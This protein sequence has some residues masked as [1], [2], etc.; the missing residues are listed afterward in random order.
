MV[1]PT[2]EKDALAAAGLAS[3]TSQAGQNERICDLCAGR[4]ARRLRLYSSVSYRYKSAAV[5]PELSSNPEHFAMTRY[6]LL[7]L[8]MLAG[9]IVVLGGAFQQKPK[10]TQPL[11]LTDGLRP[12]DPQALEL[13]D[14]AAAALAPEQVR[15]MECKVWQQGICE[16]FSYQGCGRL[17]TAPDERC[18][19]DLNVKVG[20]T[21]G[22]LRLVSDGKTLCHS[23]R[24]SGDKAAATR[25]DLPCA[26]DKFKTPLELGQARAQFLNDHGGAS[27]S[28]MLRGLRLR[29]KGVQCLQCRWNSHEVYVIAGALPQEQL[30]EGLTCEFVPA[31]FQCRQSVLYLDSQTMW[32]LRVEW[33]GAERP[34]ETS[35]LLLQTE[36]RSPVLNQ[37]LS[38]ERC[39]A[40]FTL[41]N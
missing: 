25:L 26:K 7:L 40:E 18:R 14:R 1:V 34:T 30:P 39:A 28:A 36:F 24:M 41:P 20:N 35:K 4:H 8:P 37:P 32:P 19:F 13:L 16:E 5:R 12:S 21:V 6:Q 38:T 15:W 2:P 3:R 10:T 33:W 22:E 17:L 29:M 31:R 9:A 27:L 11:L 23:I